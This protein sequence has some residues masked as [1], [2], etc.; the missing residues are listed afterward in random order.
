MA[1]VDEG[2]AAVVLWCKELSRA[3]CAQSLTRRVSG[4]P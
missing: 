2:T 4:T 1:N 3:V